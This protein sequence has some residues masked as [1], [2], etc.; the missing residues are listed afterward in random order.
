MSLMT[1]TYLMVKAMAMV[2]LLLLS[3]LLLVVMAIMGDQYKP[4]L[5]QLLLLSA[6]LLR[7][8]QQQSLAGPAG[9]SIV[10]QQQ[11]ALLQG[12]GTLGGVSVGLPQLQQQ[13]QLLGRASQ[14]LVVV[15]A[16]VGRSAAFLCHAGKLR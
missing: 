13:Q 2:L 3:L 7:L 14:Q 11:Q 8:L 16:M 10:L 4:H 1:G 15:V 12:C 6:E 5:Q 9:C